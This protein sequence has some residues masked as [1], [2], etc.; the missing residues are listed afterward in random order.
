MKK[1][2]TDIFLDLLTGVTPIKKNNKFKRPIPTTR[3]TNKPNKELKTNIYK[4]N[5]PA[6]YE[7]NNNLHVA[8]KDK[9]KIE[10]NKINKKLKKGKIPVDKK[11][12]FHGYSLFEAENIFINTI[13]SSYL[14]NLRCLLFITGKGI[15]KK[16]NNTYQDGISKLYFGKIRNNFISWTKKNELSR[17]ILNVEQAGI[18]YGADGAFFVYLRKNKF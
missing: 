4:E 7:A 3:Q 17:F 1:K 14:K 12:D 11:I 15:L 13:K 8:D 9:F 5:K 10:K 6:L 18:E 2:T 16:T